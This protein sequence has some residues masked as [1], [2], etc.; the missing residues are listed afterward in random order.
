MEFLPRKGFFDIGA[1][2]CDSCFLC[3]AMTFENAKPFP[4]ASVYPGP[5]QALHV[6]TLPTVKK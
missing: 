2:L 5:A 3:L 6:E 4:V 1:F